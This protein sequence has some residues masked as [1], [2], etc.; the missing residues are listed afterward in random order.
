MLLATKLQGLL[1]DILKDGIYMVSWTIHGGTRL[2]FKSIT[3]TG[4]VILDAGNF[5]VMNAYYYLDNCA[6][7]YHNQTSADSTV[8]QI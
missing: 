4:T 7:D 6:I 5:V 1:I 2:S 8:G 3:V